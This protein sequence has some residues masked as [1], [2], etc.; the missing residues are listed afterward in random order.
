M[1]L[2]KPSSPFNLVF[3]AVL[4]LTLTSGGT[5]LHLANQPTLT[6]PQDR[7]LDSA[8]AMWTTGSATLIGLLSSRSSSDDND[9]G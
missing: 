7:I 9:E 1:Q 3:T 5:A 8:L 2:P 4:S 6:Q